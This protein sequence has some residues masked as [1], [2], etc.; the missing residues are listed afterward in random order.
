MSSADPA[1]TGGPAVLRRRDLVLYA[2]PGAG[3]S[4][5]FALVLV[6]Y[7][8]FATDV[9]HV[10]P[11]V[12]GAVFLASR[13]W[14]AVS[15]PIAGRL[16]DSTRS[17]LGR[18]KSWILASSLPLALASVAM[19]APPGDLDGFGLT[20]W[21][22]VSVFAFYT[23]Y[24]LFEV[25]HMALGAELTFALRERNR[26]F[27]VR[28]LLR[29]LGLFAAFGIGTALLEDRA[30]A[31][32]HA[33]WL[34]LGAGAFTV[35][36]IALAVLRLPE[37]RTDHALRGGEGI[38]T[39]L[40]DVL[41]NPHARVLLFV[42]FVEQMGTGGIGVLVPYV[43]E[44][45]VG[46]PDLVAELLVVYV[47]CTVASIPLWV[48]LGGRYDKRTLWLA[49]MWMS[50]LGFGGLLFVDA[51][52]VGWM[53]VCAAVAGTAGGCGP[54]LGQAIKADVIDWDEYQTGER[55]EGAY[56]AAWSFTAKLAAGVMIGLVGFSLQASGFREGALQPWAVQGTMLFLM[57]GMP[58]IGFGLGIL[59][60]GRFTL[61]RVEHAR[62]RDAIDRGESPGARAGRGPGAP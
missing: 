62:I 58:V 5:L 50:L 55:K 35:A 8:K 2:L 42:F 51:G 16:S 38:V 33:L 11:A 47:A 36:T 44:Y 6:M 60:F 23:A 15:D 39:P 21:I 43:V 59:A 12:M 49:A 26:V 61:D 27:G 53:A 54:T 40:R 3:V 10:A 14:D 45:V 28:Q 32:T 57:G 29:S 20:V 56:F 4:F 37:E 17:R 13:I 19:W 31:R 34:A 18:R 30:T 7:M 48:G 52:T 46:R 41:R 9:L 1:P 22:T 25:P 24:T